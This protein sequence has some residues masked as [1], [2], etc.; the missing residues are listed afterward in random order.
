MKNSQ[1]KNEDSPSDMDI[2]LKLVKLSKPDNTKTRGCQHVL[3]FKVNLGTIILGCCVEIF[4]AFHQFLQNPDSC[5]ICI[6]L[7]LFVCISSDH[8]RP[9][10]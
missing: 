2:R 1:E 10:D 8:S 3:M 5:L 4:Y 6:T 9:S 7:F